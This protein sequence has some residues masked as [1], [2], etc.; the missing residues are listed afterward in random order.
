MFNLTHVG[1]TGVT[2]SLFWDLSGQ[3]HRCFEFDFVGLTGVQLV[4]F[5]ASLD[6]CTGVFFV[7]LI[8]LTGVVFS[9]AAGSFSSVQPTCS[10]LYTSDQPVSYTV[11]S[12]TLL[13]RVCLCDLSRLFLRLFCVGVAFP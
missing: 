13:L 6:N 11:H 12:L 5:G 4:R 1:S 7:E 3:Q 2:N 10:I 8:G 9:C